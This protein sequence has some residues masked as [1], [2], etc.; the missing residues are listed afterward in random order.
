MSEK[1]DAITP[2]KAGVAA[3]PE[4]KQKSSVSSGFVVAIALV[5]SITS[6]YVAW[7]A[8]RAFPPEPQTRVVVVDMARLAMAKAFASAENGEEA[9]ASA[10]KFMKE[11]DA[12]TAAYTTAGILVINSQAAFNRP[13]GT[14]VTAS[15]AKALN[16]DLGK[17]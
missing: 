4:P 2:K 17:H 12:V 14:D 7:C 6:S 3:A 5:I 10:K 15:Y 8:M 1:E 16:V 9:Q 11:M 13:P